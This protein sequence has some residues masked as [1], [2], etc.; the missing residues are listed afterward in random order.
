VSPEAEELAELRERHA[1]LERSHRALHLYAV[2]L[3]RALLEVV[4]LPAQRQV[5]P[6]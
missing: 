4:P 5:E 3:E 1:R 6:E 2:A